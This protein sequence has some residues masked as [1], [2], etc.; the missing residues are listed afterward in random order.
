LF[1]LF[2]FQ[3]G[4]IGR[5]GAGKSS[6]SLALLRIIEPSAGKI[7]IDA[8]DV[9]LIGLHDLRTKVTIIPQVRTLLSYMAVG[10]I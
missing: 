4:I 9:S 6:M 2:T 10:P 8:V 7:S 3:F 1:K 5:T